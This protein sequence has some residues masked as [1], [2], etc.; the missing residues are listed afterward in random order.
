MA[1]EGRRAFIAQVTAGAG[2]VALGG[3]GG[4]RGAGSAIDGAR[5]A[6]A[7]GKVAPPAPAVA[8]AAAVIE[9]TL[10]GGVLALGYRYP[11]ALGERIAAPWAATLVVAIHP[12]S[13]SPACRSLAS[14]AL[15]TEAPVL[16]QGMFRAAAEVDLAAFFGL[17]APFVRYVHASFL[18]L[19]SGVLRV[20]A[21]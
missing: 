20:A 11:R 7:A 6:A 18:H 10:R 13:A 5:G 21:G 9:A 3:C 4:A 15:R 12:A 17:K 16:D 19:R 8:G 14:G 2:L 1:S